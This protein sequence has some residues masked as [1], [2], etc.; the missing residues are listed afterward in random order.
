MAGPC[1][2]AATIG[3]NPSPVLLMT[4]WGMGEARKLHQLHRPVTS[5]PY[6]VRMV[7]S[8]RRPLPRIL[9]V[10]DEVDISTSLSYSLKAMGYEVQVAERGEAALEAVASFRPTWCSWTSCCP[11]YRASMCA[12]A[13]GQ[14]QRC[15]ACGDHADRQE[16]GTEPCG[17][18]RGG[19]DD[20][21]T[22]PFSIASWSFVSTHDSRHGGQRPR[23][24]RLRSRPIW[25]GRKWARWRSI[26]PNIACSC[27]ARKFA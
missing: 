27:P 12:V 22:K 7:E 19:A 18:V 1:D 17:R 14:H 13:S 8:S 23:R 25:N 24:F 6:R 5:T 21:V 15:P 10:E 2:K 20:Y 16:P 9:V 3:R 26:G 4:I 11:T